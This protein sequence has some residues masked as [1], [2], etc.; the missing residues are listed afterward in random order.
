MTTDLGFLGLGTMGAPMAARLVAAGHRVTVWNR[1]PERARPLVEAGAILAPTPG[2]VIAA[3]TVVHSMLADD[4]AAEHVFSTEAL[5]A[6]RAG[7]LH[8]NHA[9]ISVAAA[10]RLEARHRGA[11]VGYV[12]APVIGRPEVA[13]VGELMIVAAGASEHLARARPH[14][15]VLARR[16]VVAGER[17]STANVV[18]IGVN[19]DI[20]QALQAMSESIALVERYG[21]DPAVFVDVLTGSLFQGP[22]YEEYG[23]MIARRDY[24]PPAFNIA[25]GRKDL[26]LAQEAAAARGV[27]LPTA[28]ALAGVVDEALADERLAPLDWAAIAEITRRRSG[29]TPPER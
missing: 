29:M 21:I 14:F 26:R 9:T 6:A 13:E 25:L 3:S 5:A 24:L 23:D 17:P 28:E 22:V 1:S 12:A 16:V 11:D 2:D 27:V 10:D 8:V 7:S 18:K 4:A 15:D 20:V 19:Y